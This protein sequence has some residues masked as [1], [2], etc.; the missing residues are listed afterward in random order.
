[1]INL[2]SLFVA[3]AAMFMTATA[4]S[5]GPIQTI[6]F[7]GNLGYGWDGAA[8]FGAVGDLGGAAYSITLSFDTSQL[9]NDSCGVASNNSCNWN[10]GA[11]GITETVTIKGITKAYTA[12]GQIQ[13]CAC[14]ADA[15]YLST[16]G[17]GAGFSGS[18]VDSNKLFS[19]HANVNN[20]NLLLDFTNVALTSGD[21]G[22]YN[23]GPG[24][25]TSF[26]LTP[27]TLSAARAAAAVPEPITLSLF[28]AG[29]A[30]A[31]AMR[32]RR[33]RKA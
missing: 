10:F 31:V 30:G 24:G 7:S 5:A 1:M 11:S 18:F 9:K 6:T 33:A 8:Q 13:F 15:I 4:A 21:F 14:S 22:S 32:R 19:N 12:A 16:S 26:G 25:S 27:R 2:K 23:L 28:G 20:P 29:F 3:L 17:S